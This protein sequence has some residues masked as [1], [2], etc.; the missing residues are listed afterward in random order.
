M[1]HASTL[2]GALVI[3]VALVNL[4]AGKTEKAPIPRTYWAV[5]AG[6]TLAIL[7]AGLCSGLE[8]R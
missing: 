7:A 5:V 6:L 8:W 2:T 1:Q 3:A 4:P